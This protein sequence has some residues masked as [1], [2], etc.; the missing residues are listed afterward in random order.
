MQSHP[1]AELA[2]EAAR[3]AGEQGKYWEMH[4][5]LFA[6]PSEWDTTETV[7]LPVFA[8]YAKQIGADPAAFKTCMSS[9]RYQASVEANMAQGE[10]L[11]VTGTPSFIINGKLLTGA[12]PYSVFKTA[13]DR[14][15]KAVAGG[16]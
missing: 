15:L 3:C 9:R 10:H 4:T 7:A 5:A 6:A 1:Q 12:H 2:A 11:G 16:R 8:L 13:F 14:E